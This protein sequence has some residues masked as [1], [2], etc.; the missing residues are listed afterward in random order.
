MLQ[1]LENKISLQKCSGGTAHLRTFRGSFGCRKCTLLAALLLYTQYKPGV[2]KPVCSVNTNAVKNA[3][4]TL[5]QEFPNWCTCSPRH[6]RTSRGGAAAPPGLKNFRASASCPKI[7]NDKKYLNTVKIF[8]ATLIFR[9]NASCVKI[10]NNKKYKFS[11]VK[12]GHPLFFRAS[13]SYSKIL[14]VKSIFNTVKN[15]RATLFFRASASCSKIR[16]V[17]SI[18]N[19]VKIFRATLVFRASASCSKILNDK[20]YF[21]TVKIFWATLFF[22]GQ[23]QVAQIS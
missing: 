2:G 1:V 12:S 3:T 22:S 19:T 6:R 8:R 18:F 21:N 9:A 20:I 11:T 13:A 16:N 14:N 5:N 7:L 10:L 17:K 4:F 23:A 15:S